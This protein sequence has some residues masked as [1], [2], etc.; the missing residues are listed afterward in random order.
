MWV[1]GA[2]GGGLGA[3][4]RGG[5]MTGRGGSANQAASWLH[6][7]RTRARALTCCQQGLALLPTPPTQ[8]RACRRDHGICALH[9][10]HGPDGTGHGRLAGFSSPMSLASRCAATNSS[11]G[12]AVEVGVAALT[13]RRDL[14]LP[15]PP[16][17]LLAAA[18]V[19]RELRRGIRSG[20]AGWAVCAWRPEA[21]SCRCRCW[22]SLCEVCTGPS[23][24]RVLP[25]RLCSQNGPPT[26]P[27]RV[28]SG[29]RAP[30]A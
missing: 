26:C 24:C 30:T 16:C 6:S 27:T 2:A 1:G 29:C 28:C 13:T 22:A 18:P 4:R 23:F 7:C 19:C 10:R 17:L 11:A 20:E 9:C 25:T 15:A 3:A 14:N 8:T 5:G 12:E 21:N